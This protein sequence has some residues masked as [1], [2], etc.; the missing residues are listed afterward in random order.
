M[1][2]A[3][4]EQVRDE[5]VLPSQAVRELVRSGAV[6]ALSEI[7]EDQVQPASLDLRLG[8][9]AW[10]VPAS[11]LPG[12]GRSVAAELTDFAMYELRLDGDGPGGG[13]V[14]ETGCVYIVELEESLRLPR[15]VSAVTTPKS[16]TGRLDIFT[17]LIVD[18]ASEFEKVPQ[19]YEGKLYVEV[20]PRSF[21]VRVRTGTRLNQLRFRR[22]A[23]KAS[24]TALRAAHEAVG[25][26][27]AGHD[28]DTVARFKDGLRFSVDLRGKSDGSPVAYRAKRHAR[29]VIDLARIGHYDPAEFWE[30]VTGPLARGLILYPDEFYIL[31]TAEFVRVPPHL[32]AEMVAYDTN[33]GEFRVH[34][35]GFFDPGFGWSE[36]DP[37]SGTPAVLEVR[38]H[39]TPFL[40]EHGQQVGRLVYEYL[41]GVP[42]KIYG[43]GIGSNYAWQGLTL[44]KQFRR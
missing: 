38:A 9:R 10:R 44:A 11:F 27:G 5:G 40:L 12:D 24:D 19:R 13:A 17:R 33:F 20:C 36:G 22:G 14:L 31:A 41:L 6:T 39:E 23:P 2:R 34:Y 3:E 28:D 42:D 29:E 16:S 37:A 8:R 4:P 1:A 21:S 7:G 15:G 35:A 25:L 18:G 32:S 43:Q 30:P 26:V